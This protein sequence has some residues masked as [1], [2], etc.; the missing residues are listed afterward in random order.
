[1]DLI[2]LRTA[3][4]EELVEAVRREGERLDAAAASVVA[5]LLVDETVRLTRSGSREEITHAGA[6]LAR[7]LGAPPG[8]WLKEIAPSAH[9]T[10]T[11][12]VPVLA[13][14]ASPASK[15]G[16]GMVRRSWNGLADRAVQLVAAAPDRRIR[17]SDLRRELGDISESHL[18]HLL[19]D[20][21][22]ASLVECVYEHGHIV[23][24]Q[25]L[26]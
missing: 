12:L 21:E 11:G 17:R 10:A 4:I 3:T 24:R 8:R 6:T 7:L 13:A 15:D 9:R 22:A 14:A 19:S 20:L 26:P 25:V 2:A 18:S 16:G 5:G 23:V 1:M